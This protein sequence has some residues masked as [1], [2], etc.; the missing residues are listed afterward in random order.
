MRVLN[1][2]DASVVLKQHDASADYVVAE[3]MLN[4]VA[5]LNSLS[6]EM[7]D[8]LEPALKR[9]RE[10]DRVAC[11]LITGAGDRALCA[12]GDI[13]A[14]YHAMSKNHEAG[15]IVDDYPFRFFEREYRLDYLIHT[16]PKPVVA[17]GHGVVMGGGLGIFSGSQHRIV[18]ERSR[19]AFPE[20]TIGLFPDAG[21]T[22]MLRNLARGVAMFL[23]CTGS[24]INGADAIEI[25]VA[26][27]SVAGDARASVLMAL[28]E[29]EYTGDTIDASRI[30]ASL[31]DLPR[32]VLPD[33]QVSLIPQS[34]GVDGSYVDV[35]DRINALAGT[36]AWV[37]KGIEKMHSGCPTSIGVVIEQLRRAPELELADCFRLEMT[38][39]THCARF[40]DFAEGV[41][42]LLFDKDKQARW[43]YGDIAG[44]DPA[45][46]IEHFDPPWTN[47]PL[48]NLESTT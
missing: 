37:D 48:E 43:R 26:T 45:H 35:C 23:G 27:A 42:T 34:M 16:Y 18:T 11:V 13:Q 21:G 38:V 12:G 33:A 30:E 19:I 41:R 20:V 7:I 31:R 47:N 17:L 25:G 40:E 4:V 28:Q 14:L 22:W 5:T 1:D 15:R 2:V 8:I 32:P 46:V 9:W 39:A 6:I 36:S 10:D 44:L 29:V 3:A 24:H